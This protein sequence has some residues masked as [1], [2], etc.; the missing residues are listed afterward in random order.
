MK[1]EEARSLE[2]EFSNLFRSP[3]NQPSLSENSETYL[4]DSQDP[5]QQ[6]NSTTFKQLPIAE[7]E[8]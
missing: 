5:S 7:S 2:D 1:K 8:S 3:S 6:F 4:L